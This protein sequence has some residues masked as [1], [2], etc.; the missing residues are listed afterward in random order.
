[1]I[2]KRKQNLEWLEFELLQEVKLRHAIFLRQGGCSEGPFASLNLG[3]SVGDDLSLVRKNR[4]Q[5]MDLFSWN[6]LTV[7]RQVHGVHIEQV[8][9]DFSCTRD[10][11]GLITEEKGQALTI[12]HADCQAAIFYDKVHHR[13]ANIHCG[14]KGNVQNIYQKTVDR[15]KALGSNP[16]DLLVCI[17]PSLGPSKAEFIHFATEFPENFHEFLQKDYLFNLWDISHM[18]LKMAGVLSSH[19]EFANICT[20]ENS[21][22]FFSYRRDKTTGRHATVV[23]LL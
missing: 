12:L 1:M 15:F 8:G 4:Q 10:S 5:V 2:R 20:Y 18:Q 22:D 23:E 16:S 9:K 21:E 13:V 17:S 3:A 19:M 7:G 6:Q 14:W 11:D